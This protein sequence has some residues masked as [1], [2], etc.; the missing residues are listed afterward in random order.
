MIPEG[1]YLDRHFSDRRGIL[2]NWNDLTWTESHRGGILVNWISCSP[3]C[4]LPFFLFFFFFF[5]DLLE[6]SLWVGSQNRYHY[7]ISNSIE[8]SVCLVESLGFFVAWVIVWWT[9]IDCVYI[10]LQNGGRIIIG[11]ADCRSRYPFFNIFA[12]WSSLL[13]WF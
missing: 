7:L 9:N 4:S 1:S 11:L 8:V 13:F 6:V 2:V 12:L 3:A 10:C 5:F